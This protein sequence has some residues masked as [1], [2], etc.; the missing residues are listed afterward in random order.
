MNIVLAGSIQQVSIGR[1]P[2]ISESLFSQLL[3]EESN[4]RILSLRGNDIGDTG[5]KLIGSALKVNRNLVSLDLFDNKIKKQGAEA[6]GESLK[7]N[8][9][10]QSLCIG[11][12]KIGD[13]GILFIAK[14]K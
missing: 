14:V 8:N 5:A 12:N 13:E 11:K 9:Y 1:N 3:Q 7:H 4:L 6:I 2:N 10:L